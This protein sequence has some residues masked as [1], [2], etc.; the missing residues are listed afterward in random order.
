MYY[1]KNDTPAQARTTTLSEE[2]GQIKYIFSDKT[3]TLTQNI[4]TFNKC[5]IN[6]KAYG[7]LYDFSGQRVEITERTER[8]DFSWNNLADPKFSFHD[9]SLVEMVRSG[10]PE[11]QEFFRLLSLCHTVMPEEKKEG[12]LNYQAQSPDEGALVTAARNFGFVFL[13]RTPETITV[14]EMGK[15]VI[16]ELLA[17][18]DFNNMRKRMSV[19]GERK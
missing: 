8:V 9:H 14:V 6:G 10:N 2:L 12:E 19:I 18:L 7:D 11:T 15:Q 5:S 4:M 3:G 16:Y 13:S 17:I 1:P